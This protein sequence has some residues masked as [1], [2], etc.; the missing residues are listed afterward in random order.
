MQAQIGVFVEFGRLRHVADG[1][2]DV[3]DRGAAGGE[4]GADV[5]PDLLDLR[6]EVALADDIAGF[7][8]RDLWGDDDPIAAV[9]QCDLGRR[10]GSGTRRADDLRRR[11][12]LDYLPVAVGLSDLLRRLFPPYLQIVLGVG[13]IELAVDDRPGLGIDRVLVRRCILCRAHRA[14]A[15]ILRRVS[16]RILDEHV[17]VADIGE[18]PTQSMPQI[19]EFRLPLNRFPVG[20]I[21]H[22]IIAADR[23]PRFIAAGRGRKECRQDEPD[24]RHGRANELSPAHCLPPRGKR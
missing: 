8:A 4:A 15:V 21:G 13:Q 24:R 9:A 16:V 20:E 10:R 17:A 2:D 7:V 3:L 1:K 14:V 6:L 22:R 23:K 11:Q 5:L 19:F 12:L 18:A